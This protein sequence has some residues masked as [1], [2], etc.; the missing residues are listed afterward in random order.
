MP[1][2]PVPGPCP[3]LFRLR[4]RPVTSIP[5][6]VGPSI[7]PVRLPTVVPPRRP[8]PR[9]LTALGPMV[10][11]L[12]R[13]QG[14]PP[15]ARILP[16]AAVTLRPA[17]IQRPIIPPPVPARPT[18]IRG[19][20][21]RS[22]T[23]RIIRVTRATR[24]RA[25]R[26]IR[27]PIRRLRQRRRPAPIDR[28][29]TGAPA[30]RAT[31]AHAECPE[32]IGRDVGRLRDSGCRSGGRRQSVCDR[33]RPCVVRSAGSL[34]LR[35]QRRQ[36]DRRWV[37]CRPRRWILRSGRCNPGDAV[38]QSARGRPVVWSRRCRSERLLRPRRDR[39][40]TCALWHSG[41]DIPGRRFRPSPVR[42][43]SRPLRSP[44]RGS[45]ASPRPD[46]CCRPGR[47]CS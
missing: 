15:G 46:C 23:R 28:R 35:R 2:A 37:V 18:R 44:A 43:P 5:I 39:A 20:T 21:I 12:A 45:C 10:L 19:R 8:P 9:A 26:P 32:R 41:C 11:R 42:R 38:V 33:R 30:A 6:R 16:K 36:P 34:F 24:P 25:W 17:T 22:R 14:P 4:P 31:F 7:S 3:P 40:A 13:L 47:P 27:A 29:P 1:R